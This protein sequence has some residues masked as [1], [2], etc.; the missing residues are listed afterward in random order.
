MD[1]IYILKLREGK[2]YIGKTNN[3]EKRFNEHIAGNGSGWTKKYKPISLIKSV[4][5]TSYFD[6]DKYVKEYMAKY[7]IENVRGG[8]YSNIDLDANCISV[9]EK[10]IWHSKNLCTRCGRDTHF[11][12]D[13][14]AK[15]DSKDNII[16]DIV[17]KD[18]AK[19]KKTETPTSSLRPIIK[20]ANNKGIIT[21]KTTFKVSN[22]KSN[23]VIE[24]SNIRDYGRWT[25]T[26]IALKG[27]WTINVS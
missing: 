24:F 7:G 11:I 1:H 9:L 10:E 5:S 23:E 19:L 18:K 16:V 25:E 15:T 14:Y 21:P 8:T 27:S 17:S 26:D 4:V 22:N 3:V 12:K 20:T 13:C 2:Y 6:E